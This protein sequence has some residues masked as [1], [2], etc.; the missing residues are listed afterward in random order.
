MTTILCIKLTDYLS[1]V[2]AF[3]RSVF[4]LAVKIGHRKKGNRIIKISEIFLL[5]ITRGKISRF[6][7]HKGYDTTNN[8]IWGTKHIIDL[9][10][11]YIKET[12]GKQTDQRTRSL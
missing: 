3:K 7:L 10:K 11:P 9:F 5:M 1:M 2:Y 12:T 4:P 6:A 8:E